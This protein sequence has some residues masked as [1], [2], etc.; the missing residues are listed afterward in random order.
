MTDEER[1]QLKA[2]ET[3][4]NAQQRH[5][6]LLKSSYQARLDAYNKDVER[7]NQ[8]Q[9]KSAGI[10]DYLQNTQQQ[11]Q[12]EREYIQHQVDT[13]NANVTRLNQQVDHVNAMNDQFNASVDQFNQRFQPRQFD[14]GMFNGREINIYEF[15]NLDDLRITLAHEFGHGLGLFHSDDPESLMYP[16]LEKQNF[17]DFHLKPADIAL[18][19]AR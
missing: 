8:S 10:R 19:N 6:E 15:Q 2:T 9:Y 7:Y 14:K 18:L 13:F 5:I 4:L 16:I 12:Q 1:H 17:Q 11:L 3:E